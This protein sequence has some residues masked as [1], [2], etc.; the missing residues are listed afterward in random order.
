MGIL[1]HLVT[2][3]TDIRTT[4]WCMAL[5]ALVVLLLHFVLCGLVMYDICFD[6]SCPSFDQMLQC[7]V[8]HIRVV[9]IM[10]TYFYVGKKRGEDRKGEG[11]I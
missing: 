2:M 10:T 7:C 9:M 1:W 5:H 8:L 6:S 3:V 11:R 4:L